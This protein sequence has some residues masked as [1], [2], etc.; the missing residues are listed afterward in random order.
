MGGLGTYVTCHI[1]EFLFFLSFSPV[2][3]TGDVLCILYATIGS[4]RT[5]VGLSTRTNFDLKFQKFSVG[6]A[7]RHHTWDDPG[8]P[9]RPQPNSP[10][11][12]TPWLSLCI[13]CMLYG[14]ETPVGSAMHAK[15][16]LN[17]NVGVDTEQLGAGGPVRT[18]SLHAQFTCITCR[19]MVAG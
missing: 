17:N 18:C 6:N 19:C 13:K 15:L 4:K 8:D 16:S 1:S 11:S 12:E 5:I 10:H 3:F 2:Y 7:S 14:S 9:P